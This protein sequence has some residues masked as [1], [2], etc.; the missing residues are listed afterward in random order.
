MGHG[1]LHLLENLYFFLLRCIGEEGYV[2]SLLFFA[3]PD[4]ED[5]DRDGETEMDD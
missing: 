4:R 2:L 5:R 3:F 1:G